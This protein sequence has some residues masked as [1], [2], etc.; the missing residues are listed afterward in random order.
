M[1]FIG[2]NEHRNFLASFVESSLKYRLYLY[3][4]IWIISK[5]RCL[6]IMQCIQQ[7]VEAK[8]ADCREE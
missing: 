6:E 2:L 4:E 7:M 5:N 8:K 1:L 3:F